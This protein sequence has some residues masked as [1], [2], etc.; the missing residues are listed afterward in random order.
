MYEG[1]SAGCAGHPSDGLWLGNPRQFTGEPHAQ[2]PGFADSFGFPDA[3][4]KPH[5][6]RVA[7]AVAE[8]RIGMPPAAGR[9]L[10]QGDDHRC[11]GGFT[12]GL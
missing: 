11:S 8:S 2:P 1:A 9:N 3:V 6:E 10:I 12:S 7:F 5:A 4:I